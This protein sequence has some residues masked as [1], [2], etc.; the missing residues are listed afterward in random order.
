MVLAGMTCPHVWRRNYAVGAGPEVENPMSVLV[1]P[2]GGV[3]QATMN[4]S[5]GQLVVGFEGAIRDGADL[6]GGA[7][8]PKLSGERGALVPVLEGVAERECGGGFA[9]RLG[10]AAVRAVRGHSFGGEITAPSRLTSMRI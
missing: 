8:P 2:L 3:E 6:F 7:V 4:R 9:R 10:H 5:G 1:Q